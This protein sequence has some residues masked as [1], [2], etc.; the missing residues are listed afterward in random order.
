[1]RLSRCQKLK[2]ISS[3]GANR[4]LVLYTRSYRPELTQQ[5]ILMLA[6]TPRAKAARGNYSIRAN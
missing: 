1:M 2:P 5:T 6:T 4:W 3:S